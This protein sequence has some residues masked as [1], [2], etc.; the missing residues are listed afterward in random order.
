MLE[1]LNQLCGFEALNKI[2]FLM[3]TNRIDIL[4]QALLR[5]GHIDRKIKFPN[6]NED[7]SDAVLTIVVLILY[8]RS[9]SYCSIRIVLILHYLPIFPLFSV[10]L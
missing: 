1:L 2:T 10:P 3:A 4:D 9:M 7:V 6:P 8:N 5:P